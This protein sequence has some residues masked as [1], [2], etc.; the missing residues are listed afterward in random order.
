MELFAVSDPKTFANTISFWSNVYGFKMNSM[1]ESV[2]YDA[3]VMIV[4]PSCV[5]SD[6][7]KFKT[8]DCTSVATSELARFDAPFEL[9][10]ASTCELTGI[11]A[12]F[13][14]YFNHSSLKNKVR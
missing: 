5:V 10:I 12:S 14:T 6:A 3:Q 8:I 4:E 9:T 11:G 13:D 2:R 7:P 1:R